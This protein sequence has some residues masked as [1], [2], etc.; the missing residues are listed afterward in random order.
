M[1]V[2]I[3]WDLA[4]PTDIPANALHGYLAGR[5]QR[6]E[7]DTSNALR[8]YANG[9]GVS[10]LIAAD[11]P[12][13][14]AF[15]QADQQA[16]AQARQ[17]SQQVQERHRAGTAQVLMGAR[18]LPVEQRAAYI[19]DAIRQRGDV[20]SPQDQET[21]I[22]ALDNPQADLSD[23]RLDAGI[24]ASGG[25]P[26][27][28][29]RVIGNGQELVVPGRSTPIA[30]GGAPTPR[31]VSLGNGQWIIENQAEID[32]WH[33]RYGG[34][35]PAPAAPQPQGMGEGSGV[36]A[37]APPGAPGLSAAPTPAPSGQGAPAATPAPATGGLAAVFATPQDRHDTAVMLQG[38]SG[39][40]PGE[41]AAILSALVNNATAAGQ[42]AS[43]YLH[44]HPS[45]SYAF[46]RGNGATRHFD[47]NGPQGQQYGQLIDSMVSGQTPVQPFTNFEGASFPVR[48]FEHNPTT[49]G[50]TR[51]TTNPTPGGPA[52]SPATPAEQPAGQTAPAPAA[53]GVAAPPGM[54][55]FGTPRPPTGTGTERPMTQADATRL[56]LSRVIPGTTVDQNGGMHWPPGAN[57]SDEVELQDATVRNIALAYVAD[58]HSLPAFGNG[59]IGA[60]NRNRVLN[61]AS[62]I[63]DATGL[64]G[65][66]AA[67]R[68]QENRSAVS[69]LTQ[70]QRRRATIEQQ[71]GEANSTAD[72][73]LQ[74][75]PT[76]QNGGQ[77]WLNR[78][79]R[80][81]LAQ[82][83]NA[84]ATRFNNA[85]S[86]F[87][88]T[89][90]RVMTGATGSA[91]ASDSAR[92]T[93]H[94]LL[95]PDQS[96][97]QIRTN[98]AQ[99]RAEMAAQT[100]SLDAAEQA[101]RDQI[102][103]GVAPRPSAAAPTAR[104]GTGTAG[105]QQRRAPIPDANGNFYH[106]TPQQL[107]F[108]QSANTR[109]RPGA[110]DNP[111]LLHPGHE[112]A[113]YDRLRQGQFYVGPD[114]NLRQHP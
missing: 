8:T 91:A 70:V 19:A 40:G 84:G 59:P 75:M 49:I 108:A 111:F 92:A 47:P 79:Y 17:E 41:D 61:A 18:R 1:A 87:S 9:G 97:E 81:F 110:R 80:A 39:H 10:D 46:S 6:Q 3:N 78:P 13:G 28:G 23:A 64:T 12:T 77:P 71:A 51:F 45:F 31:I 96:P 11:P 20:W 107:P 68:W 60:R 62:D 95:N 104:A 86:T 38:E 44:A 35:E 56:G 94:R 76:G 66:D 65:A 69:T 112:Q 16:A 48:S 98:I 83:G 63:I 105:G 109:A 25:D 99:M 58:N 33:Q 34:G 22:A 2:N 15:R 103:T 42:T 7:T 93:A 54:R 89:Y 88:E 50:H 55:V 114:G 82:T 43:Q 100:R 27:A 72:L 102:R 4:R 24:V 26:N 14:L 101:A 57:V 29:A 73:V 5:Q 113:Q 106:P 52:S 90:A 85:V 32:A 67:R 53:G 30:H 36:G 37:P 74:A 21:A